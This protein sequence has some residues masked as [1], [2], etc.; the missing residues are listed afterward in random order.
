MPTSASKSWQAC[1]SSGEKKAIDPDPAGITFIGIQVFED[2][3]E[4]ASLDR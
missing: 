3:I 4:V 1:Y 2:L